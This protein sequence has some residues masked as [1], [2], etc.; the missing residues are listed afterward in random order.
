M[1]GDP[2]HSAQRT[3]RALLSALAHPGRVTPIDEFVEAPPELGCALAAGAFTLFDRDVAVWIAPHAAADAGA[4]LTAETGCRLV[5]SPAEADFAVLLDAQDALPLERWNGGTPEEPERS[6]SLLLR[7][8]ALSGGPQVSLAGP[9]IE[10]AATVE[11]CGIPARFWLEWAANAAS[12]PLGVDCF[13]FA[14][15]SVMGLPRTVK[16]RPA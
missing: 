1:V 2:V 16:E 15:R 4:W 13:F 12:Y 11:P 6:A 10:T 8:E 5:S 14:A 9:G 7:V 3:F